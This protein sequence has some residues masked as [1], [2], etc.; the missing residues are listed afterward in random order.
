MKKVVIFGLTQFAEILVHFLKAE[1]SGYEV[2][3][4]T[5]DNKYLP[6]DNKML[7]PSLQDLPVVPFEEVEK[8]YPP[9]EYGMFLCIGYT[10]MNMARQQK[11]NETKCKGYQVMSYIHPTAVV[12]T[13][14]LGEGTIIMENA[15]IG[16]FVKM[17]T[18]NV[19]WAAAHIAHHT[20]VED[21]NF[22]TISVGV[23]GNIKI[24]CNC[25]FGNN[26]TIKNAIEIADRT[27]VGADCYLSKSTLPD[28][29]Y[30]P[31]RTVLLENKKSLDM[32]LT[33]E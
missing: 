24:G 13:E 25:F 15:T 33:G 28:Q 26:C 27:L 30:V 16:A 14:E 10:S 6:L 2:V 9:D 17:G 3:A 21:F 1:S 12:L 29:V 7:A 4:L 23:A 18:G 19:V 11:Y 8:S 22:F 20:V 5:A 32:K 31:A